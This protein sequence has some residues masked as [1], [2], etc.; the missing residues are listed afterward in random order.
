MQTHCQDRKDTFCWACHVLLKDPFC[1]VSSAPFKEATRKVHRPQ[2]LPASMSSR[3]RFTRCSP[4]DT[5]EQ[6]ETRVPLKSLLGL[7]ERWP[8]GHLLQQRHNTVGPVTADLEGQNAVEQWQCMA[9]R[10]ACD[11]KEEV[12]DSIRDEG[13]HA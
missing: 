8:G 12:V 10:R 9:P 3:T 2:A 5:T 7:R 4:V 6:A 1:W 11:S 13:C